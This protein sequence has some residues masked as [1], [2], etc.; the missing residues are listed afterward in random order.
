MNHILTACLTLSVSLASLFA[1]VHAAEKTA[2]PLFPTKPVQL[3]SFLPNVEGTPDLYYFYYGGKPLASS[4]LN[5]Y[6]TLAT[7][8]GFRTVEKVDNEDYFQFHGQSIQDPSNHFYLSQNYNTPNGELD[9]FSMVFISYDPQDAT[10]WIKDEVLE[11]F[12][13]ESIP[14]TLRMVYNVGIPDLNREQTIAMFDKAVYAGY[15]RDQSKELEK[16]LDFGEGTSSAIMDFAA[17]HEDYSNL[18]ISMRY[19]VE[20]GYLTIHLE[21]TYR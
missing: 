7:T 18:K 10:L 17:Y 4:L 11:R 20:E 6:K 2:L 3:A 15:V 13:T 1:P 8:N 21:A 14:R 19:F 16:T 12:P 5:E 9:T